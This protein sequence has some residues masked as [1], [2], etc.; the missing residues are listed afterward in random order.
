MPEIDADITAYYDR[1]EE[2]GRLRG[3]GRLERVRT[4]EL[5]ERFLPAAPA[6]VLDVG[7]GPGAY[8]TWL[9]GRGYEVHLLDPVELHVEQARG[10]AGVATAEVGDARALPFADASADAALLLGPLYHLV[11]TDDRLLTLAEAR[12]VLRPGG[13]L[14]VAAIS[15]FAATIDG[16]LKGYMADSD[17]ERIAERDLEDGRHL[18]RAR[19]PRWFTTAYFHLPDDLAREVREAGFELSGLLAVEGVGG[20][21]TNV[22]EWLDHPDRRGALLRAIGRVESEPSLLGASAHILAIGVKP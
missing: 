18:N 3:W 9:A 1:G 2:E 22:D 19:N 11:D 15:R 13:V 8:A 4:Q 14:A 5:L 6:V 10:H 21:L 7:G 12:R 16:L 17:F 20:W